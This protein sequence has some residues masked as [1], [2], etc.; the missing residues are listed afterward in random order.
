M[1][2]NIFYSI[3]IV[4]ACIGVLTVVQLYNKKT[5]KVVPIIEQRDTFGTDPFAVAARVELVTYKNNRMDWWI[6]EDGTDKPLLKNGTL[7]MPADSIHSRINLDSIQIAKWK[8]A[9]YVQHFCEE[10]I[11]SLC[12]E[13]RHLLLFST[14]D[15]RL[16]GYMEI[17]FSCA[18]GR[19]SEGLREVIFCPE[20]VEYLAILV[21]EVQR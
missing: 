3:A 9:L 2:K 4:F 19:T 12:Y 7:T 6:D 8:N 14:P 1:K 16:S 17:C 10:N 21:R 18:D 20:R 15:N 5:E 11:L 13:P